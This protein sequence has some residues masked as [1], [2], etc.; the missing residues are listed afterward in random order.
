MRPERIGNFNVW[1]ADTTSEAREIAMDM[2]SSMDAESIPVTVYRQGSRYQA[3]GAIR[4]GLIAR[5]LYSESARKG[6]SLDSIVSATNRP[7]DSAHIA[8]I[9]DYVKNSLR[10]K[11]VFGALALNASQELNLV[12]VGRGGVADLRQGYLILPRSAKVSITD[13]QHRQEAITRLIESLPE[14][15]QLELA[16]QAV[17]VIITNETEIDQI[18]QDFADASKAKTLPPSLL[19]MFD[20]RNPA[21][22]LIPKLERNCPLLRGRIEPATKTAGKNSTKLYTANQIRS[23]LKEFLTGSWQLA[24][25][26]FEKRAQQ[27]LSTNEKFDR[28]MD[29]AVSYI[30]R[31]TKAIPVLR[32]LS[33]LEP[34]EPVSKV[35][36]IRDD[37]KAG[38]GYVCVS[39]TG[40]VILGRIGHDLFKEHP[41]EWEMFADRL[42][43]INWQKNAPIWQDNVVVPHTVKRKGQPDQA[44]LRILQSANP[45]SRAADLVRAEIGLRSRVQARL[46]S[47]EMASSQPAASVLET[48]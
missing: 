34:D 15:D 32:S 45:I 17:A 16:R 19:A 10:G 31:V 24:D 21:N 2:A 27:L 44:G 12:V 7:K 48:A 5:T 29:K 28:E 46:P 40:L 13:G 18:H 25:E 30:N 9:A 3:V 37:E 4:F 36:E 26:E 1:S 8:E 11:Y 42:A 47:E 35:A 41:D 23:F 38:G 6:A 20:T 14:D 39:A 43:R 22:R 33:E